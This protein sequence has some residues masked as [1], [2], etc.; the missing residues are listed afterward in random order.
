MGTSSSYGSV[1]EVISC[2]LEGARR[3]KI[4][5]RFFRDEKSLQRDGFW[6][7]KNFQKPL[8]KGWGVPVGFRF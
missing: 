5:L 6:D 7:G 4:R 2:R 8:V 1:F 3:S